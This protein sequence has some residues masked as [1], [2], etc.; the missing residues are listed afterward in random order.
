MERIR[1]FSLTD[2]VYN[3]IK[4]GI[5]QGKIRPQEKLDINQLAHTLGVSRMPVVDALTRLETEGLVERRNRVGTFV[6]TISQRS[7][8]ELFTARGMIEDWA[9][10][11]VIQHASD[12]D[13]AR[14]ASLL[15]EAQ[16]KLLVAADAQFDFS[17]FNEQYDMGFHLGLVRLAGNDYINESYI[18]LNSRIRVGRVFV[19][20]PALRSTMAQTSHEKILQTFQARDLQAAL[21]AQQKHRNDSLN[22]TLSVMKELRIA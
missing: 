6:R 15:A 17:D 16:Q 21:Q 1:H 5:I 20:M 18:Q 10:P 3:S 14:L 8:S 19:P 13:F 9:T 4:T 11:H 2:Q 12:A 22:F 7:F